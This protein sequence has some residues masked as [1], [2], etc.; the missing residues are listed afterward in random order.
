MNTPW[1]LLAAIVGLAVLYVLLPVVVA[2]FL[3]FRARQ[4]LM[5]PETGRNAELIMDA[6]RAA[7]TSAF[8]QPRP[9][10]K[11]CS[12]WPERRGCGLTCL[13]LL[14]EKPEAV[15]PALL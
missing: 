7:L 11:D 10:V 5:C 13:R 12:L 6:R 8:G 1:F 14:E 3:R 2:T 9:R 4:S 15:R